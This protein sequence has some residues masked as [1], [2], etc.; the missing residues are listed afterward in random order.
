[1]TLKPESFLAR[2][3]SSVVVADASSD[4]AN[5]KYALARIERFVADIRRAAGDPDPRHADHNKSF[6]LNNMRNIATVANSI[7]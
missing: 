2:A 3:S 5:L 4:A 1:M 7:K 6:I